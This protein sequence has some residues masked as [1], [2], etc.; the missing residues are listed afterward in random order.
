MSSFISWH[1]KIIKRWGKIL[2]I[3]DYGILWVAFIKGV[4]IGL[5]IYHFFIK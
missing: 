4:I 2:N 1:K 3:S 5:L